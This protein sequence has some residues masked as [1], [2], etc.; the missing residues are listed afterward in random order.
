MRRRPAGTGRRLTW[1]VITALVCASG[2]VAQSPP[3]EPVLPFV[4]GERLEYRVRVRLLGTIGTGVLAVAGRDSVRGTPTW[5]LRFDVDAGVGGLRGSDHSASWIDP[6]HMTALRYTRD[7]RGLARS[8]RDSVEIFPAERRWTA[9]G[10]ETGATMG[11]DPVDELSFIFLLRTLPLDHDTT[12]VLWRHFDPARSPTIVRVRG[13]EVVQTEAGTYRTIVVEMVVR[14]ARRFGGGEGVIRFNLTADAE[15]VPVR[16]ESPMRDIGTMTL[17][18]RS[19][20]VVVPTGVP[21]P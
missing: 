8:Q 6:V 19:R 16:I 4:V 9:A 7:E 15:R 5:V 14:D 3:V 10:G 17:L 12:I 11:D 18:L 1:I 20:S 13:Y 21:F 2:L